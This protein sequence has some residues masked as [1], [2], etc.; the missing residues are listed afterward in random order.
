[1]IRL[2]FPGYSGAKSLQPVEWDDWFQSF[3]DNNLALVVQDSTSRGQTSNFNKLIGRETAGSRRGSRR[4][5]E[6]GSKVQAISSARGTR[7]KTK[8]TR[9][10]TRRAA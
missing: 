9:G 10:S 5:P 1:M 7:A 4:H 6:R 3:D 2:D 8:S